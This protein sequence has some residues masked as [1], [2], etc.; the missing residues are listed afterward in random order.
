MNTQIVVNWHVTE[1]C[2]YQ[3]KFCFAHWAKP[4]TSEL[5]RDGDACS[6][7]ISELRRFLSPHNPLWKQYASRPPRL[8]IAGGEPTLWA[9]ELCRVV[10]GASEAGFDVSLIS[11]GSR[12]D[13]LLRVATKISM[14]GI[15]VDS[16][17]EG[18]NLQIGRLDR[19]GRQIGSAD[20]IDL[21]R[22]LRSANP[23]L[24]IKI[25]T[26]VNAVNAGEDFSALVSQ[27]SPDRW[28]ALRMLPSYQNNLS[29][30]EKSFRAF[31][32]RHSAFGEI[33]SV[34]DNSDMVQSYLMVDPH[35]HFFQNRLDRKGYDY[36]S[37]ILQVGAESAF[38][39][40]SFKKDKF[41]AR[42]ET[43]EQMS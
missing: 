22:E 14:L 39:Q 9:D 33:L 27:I 5:W 4:R 24:R 20:L 7:L 35:G 31:V 11:N 26:V 28:K 8:N 32:R 25:N 6:E 29:V 40:I 19:K 3:C 16:T 36:S 38:S 23:A 37:P 21:V 13:A 2:N 43:S 42:Y 17:C 34:E 10:D 1:A 41:L 18:G 12:P 15:S 30:D